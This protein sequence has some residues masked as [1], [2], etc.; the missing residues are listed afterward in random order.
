MNRP[1]LFLLAIVALTHGASGNSRADDYKRGVGTKR[2]TPQSTPEAEYQKGN[3]AFD[4]KEWDSAKKYY[5]AALRLN[6][7]HAPSLLNRG[8][9]ALVT[10]KVNDAAADFRKV[11]DLKPELPVA[12]TYL[13]AALLDQGKH[14]DA[15]VQAGKAVELDPKQ[16]FAWYIRGTAQIHT[17]EF[18]KGIDDLNEAAKLVPNDPVVF[19]NRGIA[20]QKLGDETK[21]KAD[22]DRRDWLND[23][24]KAYEWLLVCEKR[25]DDINRS[26]NQLQARR[27]PPLSTQGRY[28][29]PTVPPELYQRREEATREWHKAG[30]AYSKFK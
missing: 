18:R 27:T 16:S 4:R 26:I 17:G 11:T 15:I 9:V 7:D 12:R 6:A 30:E 8:Q 20:W 3:E 5:D 21:A 2:G 1:I 10:G 22:F 28:I 24:Q 29:V 13:A 23:K 19:N 25:L 14:A